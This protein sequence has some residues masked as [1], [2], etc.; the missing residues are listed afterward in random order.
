MGLQTDAAKSTDGGGGVALH[1]D[2]KGARGVGGH[3][4]VSGA[5]VRSKTDVPDLLPSPPHSG[6]WRW[7]ILPLGRSVGRWETTPHADLARRA[8][9]HAAPPS[10][11]PGAA[12]RR[13]GPPRPH[14]EPDRG[15]HGRR[16]L[17][18]LRAARRRLARALRHGRPEP[19]R[20][21]PGE[22][23]AGRG[24]R[25][26]HRAG[27]QAAQPRR[28]ASPPCLCLPP[29]DGGGGLPLLPRRAGAA[30][31]SHARRAH[32]PE[33]YQ[34]HLHGRRVGGPPDGRD[35]AGRDDC[36][37]RARGASARRDGA[38]AQPPLP[39]HRYGPGR[40]DR[41]RPRGAARA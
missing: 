20:R 17:L 35:G 3:A 36:R 28:R 14:R 23:A 16:G 34:P 10:R 6:T 19:R 31:R 30:G 33:P 11:G 2:E 26:P 18:A 15:Q 12:G 39:L 38:G 13:A 5:P 8:A 24:P 29:G 40:G 21:P 27:R 22:P 37:R 9:G 32:G 1:S 25:R 4:P 7:T 41:P